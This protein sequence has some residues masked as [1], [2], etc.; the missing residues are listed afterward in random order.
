[1]SKRFV[2]RNKLQTAFNSLYRVWKTIFKIIYQL[3]CSAGHPVLHSQVSYH[4]LAVTPFLKYSQDCSTGCPTKLDSRNKRRIWF[5]KIIYN[6][7]HSWAFPSPRISKMLF[8]FLCCQ[9]Y[10][11]YYKLL[12]TT[13]HSYFYC[14]VLWDTNVY[15]IQIIDK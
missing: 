4:F 15:W 2:K 14:Q 9:H 8:A 1:M 10:H 7:R 12:Q 13:F 11:S 3:Q 6:L 5:F